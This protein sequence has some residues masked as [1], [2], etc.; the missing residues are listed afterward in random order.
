MYVT[1]ASCRVNVAQL[2]ILTLTPAALKKNNVSF[3]EHANYG[4]IHL[5]GPGIETNKNIHSAP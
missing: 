5:K 2:K 3:V 4:N 1:S